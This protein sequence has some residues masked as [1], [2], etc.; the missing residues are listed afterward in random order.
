MNRFLLS[1]IFIFLGYTFTLAQTGQGGVKGKVLDKES[2]EGV[3]FANISVKLKGNLVTGGVADFDGNYTIKPLAPGQYS[4]E[5]SYVGYQPQ[6]VQGVI[7]NSDKL[8]FQNFKITTQAVNLEDVQVIAYA[9]PL[10][11]KDN[12]TSG[13]QITRDDIDKIPGRSATDVAKTVG[14]LF[15][16][17][18]G[19]GDL[20]SRG[21]RDD[22]NII[23]VDGVPVRG[24]GNISK[25]ALEEV[26]VITGGVP[27]QYQGSTGAIISITTR[28]AAREYSGSIDYLTSG[29]KIGDNVYGLDAQG[30][31]LLEFNATGPLLWRKDSEGNKT[32]PILGFFV[33]GNV[34]DVIDNEPSPIGMWKVKD[35]VYDQ[36]SADP[37]RFNSNGSGTFLNHEF[38]RLNDLEKVRTRLNVRRQG[39]N[40]NAKLDY[41]INKNTTLT[42]GGAYD[43]QNRNDDRFRSGFSELNPRGDLY[44]YTLMNSH[45]NPEI[46]NTNAR[47]YVRLVQRFGSGNPDEEEASASIVKNAYY[48]IQADYQNLTNK[49]W[50]ENLRD[51]V[52]GYGYLGKFTTYQTRQYD[53]G[54]D[55]LTGITGLIQQTFVDT[56]VAFDPDFTYNPQAATITEGF[57]N[58]YGWEGIDADGNPIYD[59]ELAGDNLRNLNNISLAGGLRNGDEPRDIYGMWRSPAYVNNNYFLRTQEQYRL[60]ALFS[61]DIKDHAITLGFEY[62]QRV[63][64]EFNSSP[65]GLWTLGRQ[66]T[67]RH[68]A[69]LDFSNPQITQISTFPIVNYDRLNS[70]PDEAWGGGFNGAD[71][72]SFFDYNLRLKLGL[73]PDGVDYVDFD[74]YGPEMYSLDM[75][76]PDELLN[77]GS[78]YVSYF[79]Y[80]H[81]GKRVN[82]Y[83]SNWLNEFFT[84]QDEFGNFKREIAPFQPIYVAGFIQDKFSFDDLVFNV[85]LRV[86]R[87]DANQKVLIDPYVLFPTVKA[88]EDLTQQGI[89]EYEV[90][91][92]IG[93]DYVVYVDD[94]RNPTS[95]VGFRD[96]DTWYNAQGIEIEDATVLEGPQGIAPLLVDKNVSSGQEIRESSFRDY[97]PRTAVMPRISFSFPISDEALFFAHYDVLTRRPLSNNRLN[98]TDYFFI[99]NVGQSL[100]NNPDL[101]FEQ[102]IDYELG[103]KQKLNNYSSLSIASFYRESRDLQ[104]VVNLR[105]AYP[106]GYITFQNGDFATVKGLQLSYDLRRLGNIR[107]RVSY[108]L[109]FAEGTGSGATSGLN[110]A[111]TGKPNL[112]NLIPLSYDQ[113]HT[114]IANIDYRY[115]SGKNYNGPDGFARK[116]LENF[117][118]N[119]VFNVGSGTPYNRQQNITSPALFSSNSA[120]LEG[121]LNG[122]RLP[123]N[124]SVN[125]GVDKNFDLK[126]NKDEDGKASYTTP[127]S[128]YLQIDNLFNTLNIVNV[129]RAT[130]NPDDDGYLTAPEFQNIIQAQNSELSFRELYSL[131][132]NTG[133]NYTLPRRIKI[134]VRLDF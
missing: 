107:G 37:L 79:G 10:I 130:G 111:R 72:Q 65:R 81:T 105:Q 32:D 83:S 51:N 108:T 43:F 76:S 126:W 104:Q 14:G 66:L 1:V 95:V 102:T 9:V 69:N 16:K 134:G 4:I 45:H 3:P 127:M 62:E 2:G 35:E 52:F 123:W 12:T 120:I 8:T 55:S 39:V 24:T 118:V 109:Q 60:N 87:Y 63:D 61:A 70:A 36:L 22:A 17:D 44:S 88:G 50:D 82:D 103:F 80:D 23:Y 74:S 116:I 19:S 29:Y 42:F 58:L 15:S 113:R 5:A 20:N 110:L 25:G 49:S 11:S 94:V 57:Y 56:L 38:V 18:D 71:P 114:I 40:V 75:F 96:G 28:G 64:R 77:N 122:A 99:N 90:P 78:E 86:D 124:F 6:L 133:A 93:E 53:G 92:N 98:P 89:Q 30:Y 129:Y 21:A 73:D 47:A 34:T 132:V 100:I 112:R 59:A 26:A 97:K 106:N 125:L 46:I 13:D 48:S 33:S 31:N 119:S 85:G 131:K 7:V 117:G 128:V 115:G 67:N 121:Q 84:A 27:A 68:I 54:Q 41:N 91:N 101:G